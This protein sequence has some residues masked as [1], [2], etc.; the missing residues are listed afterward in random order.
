MTGL[1]SVGDADL[2]PLNV[3]YRVLDARSGRSISGPKTTYVRLN[4]IGGFAPHG[5]QV[6]WRTDATH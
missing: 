2:I 4:P 1:G 5:G 6:A 3:C